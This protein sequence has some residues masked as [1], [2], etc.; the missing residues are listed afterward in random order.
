[1][2][3][4]GVSLMQQCSQYHIQL[5]TYPDIV[6]KPDHA[7]MQSSLRKLANIAVKCAGFDVCLTTYDTIRTKEVTIPVDSIGR[8]ILGGSVPSNE[9]DGWFTSRGSGT[10][11][12]PSAPQK[13]HQ[14]SVLHR[15]S[16]FRVI[17]MDILG[18]KGDAISF[19]YLLV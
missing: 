16:W 1:M 13:C 2:N 5:T 15:L 14:L 19:L 4:R 9:D 3:R 6:V 7:G 10:Q 17:F 11:S 8:A 12:G 18:Q